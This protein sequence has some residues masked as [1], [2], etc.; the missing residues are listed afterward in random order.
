[1]T[2]EVLYVDNHVLAVAKPAGEPVVPDESGDTSLLDRAR[3]WVRVEFEKPGNVFLGVVHRLDRPVSGVVALARTSK[4]AA[5]L[6]AAFRDHTAQKTYL[7]LLPKTPR[8]PAGE[9]V[10]WLA[11]DAARNHVSVVPAHTPGARE[12]V[13]RWRV[14]VPSG[15]GAGSAGLC[16]VELE[17]RTGR[18]HQL[19]LAC[20]TLCAPL[21]GDLRYGASAPLADA[22]IGLHAWQ[23]RVQHPTRDEALHFVAPLPA[24][25]VW[26]TARAA[27]TQ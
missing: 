16:V 25:S 23:L 1:M 24:L 12:A 4:G 11:K 6:T 15:A 3:E 9:L 7:G 18:S 14:V 8:E 21:L 20:R 22:S 5:R 17:P 2:L 26:D 27:L 10:Q 19:R 13:T